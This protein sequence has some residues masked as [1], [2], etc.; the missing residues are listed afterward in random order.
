[1]RSE[2][3]ERTKELFQLYQQGEYSVRELSRMTGIPFTTLR[4]RFRRLFGDDYTFRAGGEGT[5]H[6]VVREYLCDPSLTPEQQEEVRLWY[7][8]HQDFLLQQSYH[9]QK[10]N[11]TRIYSNA[12][13]ERDCTFS[14]SFQEEILST[15]YDPMEIN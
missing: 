13:V 7:E 14:V 10:N 2:N 11:A 5:I 1:M 12:K 6:H 9:D 3:M 8:T 4:D 15:N